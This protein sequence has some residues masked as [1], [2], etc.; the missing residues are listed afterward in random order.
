MADGAIQLFP[1]PGWWVGVWRNGTHMNCTVG[2]LA[3]TRALAETEGTCVCV[4]VWGRREMSVWHKQ[5]QHTYGD[6]TV[7]LKTMGE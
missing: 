7:C 4:L 5:V 6:M 3:E 1:L 2:A